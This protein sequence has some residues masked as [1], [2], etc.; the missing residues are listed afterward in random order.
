[1]YGFGSNCF[2]YVLVNTNNAI[3]YAKL[4]DTTSQV[5]SITADGNDILIKFGTPWF[6]VTFISSYLGI[7]TFERINL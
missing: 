6:D 7:M 4:S 5:L 1:M 3:N 2:A